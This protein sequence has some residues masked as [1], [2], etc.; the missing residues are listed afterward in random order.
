MLQ[1]NFEESFLSHYGDPVGQT[2]VVKLGSQS[3][4]LCSHLQ[5][6]RW[7]NC[8]HFAFLFLAERGLKPEPICASQA[9]YF[10]TKAPVT[11]TIKVHLYVML[12]CWA[13]IHTF[14][15]LLLRWRG[16]LIRFTLG[17][18]WVTFR[19]HLE[20]PEL[21][22]SIC[23]RWATMHTG[24]LTPHPSSGNWRDSQVVGT[25]H[26]LALVMFISSLLYVWSQDFLFLSIDTGPVTMMFLRNREF[27]DPNLCHF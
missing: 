19:L 22:R 21:S 13:H 16:F 24:P 23:K 11:L 27:L 20:P 25:F 10:C 5:G 7:N 3:L 17:M 8:V 18:T 15:S 6:L 4:Y 1:E 26:D 9:L 2:K 12:I 14:N